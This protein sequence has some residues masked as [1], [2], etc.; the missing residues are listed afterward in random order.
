MCKG[1]SRALRA[2]FDEGEVDLLKVVSPAECVI[3][4]GECLAG[5]GKE[6]HPAHRSI[7]PVYHSEEDGAGLVVLLLYIGFA[8][9]HKWFITGAI[10]LD[11]LTGSLGDS[12]Q[13]VVLVE[14]LHGSERHAATDL[15]H[16]SGDVGGI[17]REKESDCLGDVLWSAC[18]TERDLCRPRLGL[19]LAQ[20]RGHVC[21]DESRGYRIHAYTTTAHLLSERLR[22]ADDSSLRGGVL[23]RL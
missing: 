9:L 17:I 3:K 10:P 4:S 16:L 1:R 5:S 11:D 23:L 6:Y 8:G 18:P 22:E 15:Q 19:L 21:L 2:T 20:L 14:Y 13:M 7:E 12:E